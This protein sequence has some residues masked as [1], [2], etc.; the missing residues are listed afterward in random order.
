MDNINQNTMDHIKNMVDNGDLNG[1][2]SQISP[3][4]IQNF[5]KMF[6]NADSNK[7][8]SENTENS[9]NADLNGIDL[10]QI[11]N[12][13]KTFNKQKDNPRNNLLN[14][15]KPYLRDEKKEKLDKYMNLMNMGNIAELLK[16]NQNTNDNTANKE[17]Q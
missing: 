8:T 11:M 5:S 16:N 1:A 13:A 3:E 4:M 12:L 15:L 14:S 9:T 7:E 17:K 2:I 6:A 10:N